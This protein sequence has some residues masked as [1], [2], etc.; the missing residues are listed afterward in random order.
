VR[1]AGKVKRIEK[2]KSS[3]F[4]FARDR[5]SSNEVRMDVEERSSMQS[6]GINERTAPWL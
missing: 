5:G 1:V 2:A 4:N 6:E 3:A